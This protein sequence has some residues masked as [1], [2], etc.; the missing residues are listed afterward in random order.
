MHLQPVADPESLPSSQT[1]NVDDLL[2]GFLAT[3]AQEE[4]KF[5]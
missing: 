3:I 2:S 1:A 5:K 4:A